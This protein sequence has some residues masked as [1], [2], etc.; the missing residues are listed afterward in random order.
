VRRALLLAGALAA[1]HPAI[2][3]ARPLEAPARLMVTAR[4]FS[5]VL[6]RPAIRH[7]AAIVQLVNLGEDGHDLRLVRLGGRVASRPHG[8]PE[9]RPGAV[10]NWRGRLGA[11]RYEV[12]CSL[13]GHERRGM[14]AVLRVR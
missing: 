1:L 4:E 14:R 2:A 8:T 12:F 10:S 11:G 7:G 3:A 5:L 9:T 13:P 6:S